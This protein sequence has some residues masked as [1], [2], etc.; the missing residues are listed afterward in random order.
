ME[1]VNYHRTQAAAFGVATECRPSPYR[2]AA[3]LLFSGKDLRTSE[4]S[5]F[6]NRFT[7]TDKWKNR[8]FVRLKPEFKLAWLYLL[9]KC[10]NCGVI[11]LIPEVA[12]IEIGIEID[13]SVFKDSA[14]DRKTEDRILETRDGKWWIVPFVHRQYPGGLSKKQNLHKSVIKS[15][16]S[17]GLDSY[18]RDMGMIRNLSIEDPSLMVSNTIPDPS[19]MDQGKGKGKGKGKGS[20]EELAKPVPILENP[21][22]EQAIIEAWNSTSGVLKH[23]GIFLSATRRQ[24][25]FEI[26]QSEPDWI[27]RFYKSLKKFPLKEWPKGKPTI[28]SFLK[29]DIVTKC[30]EGAY[31]ENATAANNS[32]FEE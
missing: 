15:L 17:H 29:P 21:I 18:A 12:N 1:K 28:E 24:M 25:L 27:N 10:D 9:D 3:L 2:R 13:W 6:V 14:N 11:D 16:V 22:D 32:F 4:R 7:E 31:D 8:W 19:A 5:L 20:S 30:L 23:S 26:V